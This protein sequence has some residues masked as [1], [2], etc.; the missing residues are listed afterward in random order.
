MRFFKVLFAP[1]EVRAALGVLDEAEYSF[2]RTGPYSRSAAFDL[3]KPYAE[4]FILAA[5]RL[6]DGISPREHVYNLIA[7]Y[8]GD[9]VE[10]GTYHIRRG[11]LDPNGPGDALYNLFCEAIDELVRIGAMDSDYAE[12]QRGI[13]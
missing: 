8:A 12:E 13:L 5:S 6:P 1:K 2:C 11:H 9:L 4:R 7:N 3:V 10:S